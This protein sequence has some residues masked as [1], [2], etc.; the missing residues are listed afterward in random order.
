MNKKIIFSLLF[1]CAHLLPIGA[2]NAKSPKDIEAE[3]GVKVDAAT[4]AAMS[5][6]IAGLC[7]NI[8]SAVLLWYE[9]DTQSF[10]PKEMQ[11]YLRQDLKM[12]ALVKKWFQLCGR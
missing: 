10:S 9:I 8:K 3:I 7:S 1:F 5:G 12:R 11:D 2:A 6:D 4:D